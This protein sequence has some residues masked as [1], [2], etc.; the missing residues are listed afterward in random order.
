MVPPTRGREPTISPSL[1]ALYATVSP[2]IGSIFSILLIFLLIFLTN[3]IFLSYQRIPHLPSVRTVEN[4]ILYHAGPQNA[5]FPVA[6]IYGTPYELGF[7]MGTLQKKDVNGFV[8]KTWKYL[9]DMIV[10]ELPQ[11]TFSPFFLDLILSKGMEKA[12]DWCLKTT[13]P[14]TP[15]SYF[16]E[17]R[18]IA[19]ASGVE[20]DMVVRLNLFAEI[21]KAS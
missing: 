12:L 2:T 13:A 1:I 9:L 8:K 16:D 17:M 11:G 21:T 18:G 20:Y 14:Y 5:T 19:D 15:Q 7:A 3:F 6:H 10:E 4:G